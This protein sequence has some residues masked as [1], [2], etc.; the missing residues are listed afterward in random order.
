MAVLLI[1]FLGVSAVSFQPDFAIAAK[2]KR[3]VLGKS[4]DRLKPNCGVSESNRLCAAEGR[5][6][7]YQTFARGTDRK[8]TF[9]VPFKGKIVSWSIQLAKPTRKYN[10]V[11]KDAQIP[12]FNGLFGSPSQARIAVLRQVNKGK[13]GPPRFK[14]VRQSPI[15]VLNPYFGTNVTFALS[16]PL[17]VGPR[18]VVGL[19]IPTWAPALWRPGSCDINKNTGAEND[20]A[21]CDVARKKY[22]WRGS[23]GPKKCELGGDTQEEIDASI[24][25]SHPQSKVNSTKR[26]GCYYTGSRLLYTATVV[27]KK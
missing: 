24:A 1:L 12:F 22:T 26:Y 5:V 11:V 3:V 14:M 16:K 27:G 13:K 23:R 15:Q 25:S 17:N 10:K 9:S 20:A 8:R 2:T 6:T 7:G 4:T 18:Q 21:A 19:T